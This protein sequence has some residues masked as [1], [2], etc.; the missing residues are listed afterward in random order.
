[1]KLHIG[2]GSVYLQDYC[3]VDLEGPKTFLAAERPDLV[4]RWLTT[5]D[6][7]YARHSDKTIDSLRVGPLDQEYVCDLYGSFL[8][9]PKLIRAT[10]VLARHSFE[11]LSITE[12]RAALTRLHDFILEPGGLLRIDVPDH[13]ETLRLL[14]ETG[15]RFYVRHLLGPRR[16]DFG[17]HMMSYTR[18]RLRALVESHG[19]RFVEEEPNIH[20]YPAFCLRFEKP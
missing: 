11:H 6:R 15:D 9:W 19:F 5:E 2:C 10:E 12:A 7:Y 18:E 1:M 20:C 13:D 17:F 16:G 3:N 14:I 4:E 8:T